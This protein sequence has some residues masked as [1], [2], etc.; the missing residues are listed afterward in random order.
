[1]W[2]LR[3]THGSFDE[4]LI[5]IHLVERNTVRILFLATVFRNLINPANRLKEKMLKVYRIVQKCF[6]TF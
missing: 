5:Q 6:F 1:M 2:C 3:K 4:Q